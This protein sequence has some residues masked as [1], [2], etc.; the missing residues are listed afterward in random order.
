MLT[1]EE[2]TYENSDMVLQK[3]NENTMYRSYKNIGRKRTLL[4]LIKK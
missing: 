4:L 1:H 3:D 2:K